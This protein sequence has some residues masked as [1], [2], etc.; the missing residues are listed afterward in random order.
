M[1]KIDEIE[2]AKLFTGFEGYRLG[3][4]Y[5]GMHYDELK[6]KYKKS[7]PDTIW[8]KYSARSTKALDGDLL[9]SI[10]KEKWA[11][12]EYSNLI[13]EEDKNNKSV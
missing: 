13:L 9:K 10:V 5:L 6:E 3:D 11:E 1:K 4:L 8:G 2:P 7:V 12:Q